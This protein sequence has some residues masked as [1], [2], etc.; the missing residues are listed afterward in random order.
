[1][2]FKRKPPSTETSGEHDDESVLPGKPTM[3]RLKSETALEN[4]S[5]DVVEEL[6]LIAS[7]PPIKRLHSGRQIDT[8]VNKVV[9]W[10]Q[11]RKTWHLDYPE[12][13]Q[14]QKD[15]FVQAAEL[16]G[17]EFCPGGSPLWKLAMK[18]FAP[19]NAQGAS[20]VRGVPT[21]RRN[22]QMLEDDPMEF[23]PTA[24]AEPTAAASVR[25]DS[26]PP[27]QNPDGQ[28][29]VPVQAAD[30]SERAIALLESTADSVIQG[31]SLPVT[32]SLLSFGRGPENTR[33]FEPPTE[34]RV[35]KYAFKILLWKEG[36][37][38][39]KDPAKTTPPWQQGDLT[40]SEAESYFFWICTKATV[41]IQINGYQLASSDPRNPGGPS[42][43]WVRL[44]DKDELVIWGGSDTDNH[45]KLVFRSF[46]GGSSK[47]RSS[48]SRGFETAPRELV[49]K[50][51]DACQLTERRLR[52]T[53]DKETSKNEATLDH[54]YRLRL[55]E[56]E[57]ERSR[58]FD[59]KR[60]EAVETLRQ[61]QAARRGSP[62]SVASTG[63]FRMNYGGS[64]VSPD[65]RGPHSVR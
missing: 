10:A 13:T 50:L 5:D 45:T 32:N 51:N 60:Q 58:V 44:H 18:Y 56:R 40:P 17:E 63:H 1:M 16:R 55:V 2:S 42:Q 7:I 54:A 20:Q 3:K 43:F 21:M 62:A 35:P 4:M 37:D 31:I 46:W 53:R 38:P 47:P 6:K 25:Y 23:P 11:D 61:A 34:S 15:A 39:S 8:P 30:A 49:P 65:K 52:D 27:T 36:Y 29:V 64:S 57:R 41:G 48:E 9:F 28:I 12:M 19:T 22:E 33:V 24:A 59:K 14:L 26:L